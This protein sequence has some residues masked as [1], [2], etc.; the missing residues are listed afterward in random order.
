MFLDLAK[1]FNTVTHDSIRKALY[2]KGIPPE[3]IEGIMDMNK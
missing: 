2:K 3:V 1:A